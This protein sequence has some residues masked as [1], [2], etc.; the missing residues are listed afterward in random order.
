MTTLAVALRVSGS[1][2]AS[3][4]CCGLVTGTLLAFTWALVGCTSTG[5]TTAGSCAAAASCNGHDEV[6][7]NAGAGGATTALWSQNGSKYSL[8]FG[9]TYFE[10]DAAVGGR[11]TS[12][13]TGA[14]ELLADAATTGQDFYWGSTFWPSPQSLFTLPPTND[15][16][17]NIDRNPYS[18]KLEGNVLTLTSALNLKAP[19]LVVT[20]KFSADLVEEAVAIEYTM[21][22]GGTDAL[23]VAPWEVTRVA[24]AGLTFY[25]EHTAPVL[26]DEHWVLPPT[27]LTAGVRWFKHD[28]SVTAETKFFA[29]GESGWISQVTGANG[30]LLLIKTFPDIQPAQSP[31]GES[32]VEVFA[33]PTYVEV[34]QQGPSQT[35]MPGQSSA[36]WTVRWYAR[37]LAAPA[38]VGSADLVTYVQNQIK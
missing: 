36:H 7:D 32:E 34:E 5:D 18:V 1:T 23:T 26:H 21:T 29:D 19:L 22:N 16:L 20:K 11:I 24:S 4:A 2:S 28:P 10:V 37:K 14:A 25:P 30:E 13:K 38:T 12:F 17:S 15:S 6:G 9:S 8:S 33:A 27:T 3:S 35:L 31:A